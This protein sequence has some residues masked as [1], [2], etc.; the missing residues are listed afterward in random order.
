MTYE[1]AIDGSSAATLYAA[2][3]RSHLDTD[4]HCRDQGIDFIPMVMEASGGSWG[5]DARHVLHEISKCAARTTGDSPAEKLEQSTQSLSICLHRA[6][7]RAIAC[8]APAA[9][10]AHSAVAVAQSALARAA[11]EHSAGP[12]CLSF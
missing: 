5:P 9:A 10:P 3:K 11:A 1:S 6:N 2:R 4:S 7:A 8:R 12:T